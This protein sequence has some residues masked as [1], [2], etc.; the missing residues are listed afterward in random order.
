[1]LQYSLLGKDP[2]APFPGMS[3]TDLDGLLCHRYRL[4]DGLAVGGATRKPLPP[5]LSEGGCD[6][7]E[8]LSCYI[9]TE[10]ADEVRSPGQ[11][12]RPAAVATLEIDFACA[13]ARR[14]AGSRHRSVSLIGSSGVGGTSCSDD[15][16]SSTALVASGS[17]IGLVLDPNCG[18]GSSSTRLSSTSVGPGI[19]SSG[20]NSGILSGNV[21][22]AAGVV[23]CGASSV[24]GGVSGGTSDDVSRYI[25]GDSPG[26]SG[27]A[28]ISIR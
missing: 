24:V 16:F 27:R 28:S 13:P 5:A 25:F 11:S 9:L 14:G 21:S 10:H 15:R 23:S 12:N 20:V 4:I 26:G 8:S 18:S 22:G 6:N 17:I 2:F 1:M 19:G 3:D 7:P